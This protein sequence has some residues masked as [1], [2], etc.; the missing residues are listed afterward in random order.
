VN[1]ALLAMKLEKEQKLT[2]AQIRD[3]IIEEFG[4]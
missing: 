3:R 4:Q 1:E 2:P